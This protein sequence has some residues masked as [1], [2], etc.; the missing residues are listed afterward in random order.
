M[1]KFITMV[2]MFAVAMITSSCQ[3]IDNLMP[4]PD[5]EKIG[6]L[7]TEAVDSLQNPIFYSVEDVMSYATSKYEEVYIDSVF[8][9]MSY[10][11]IRNVA[12]VLLRSSG[13]VTKYDIVTEYMHNDMIYRN[14]PESLAPP[15]QDFKEEPVQTDS[16]KVVNTSIVQHE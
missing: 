2:I 5:T 10:E 11:D 14:L 6:A 3:K 15:I 16:E 7:V 8:N 1:K 4:Q 13:P 9:E 12:T